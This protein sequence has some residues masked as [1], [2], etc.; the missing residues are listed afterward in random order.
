MENPSG[1]RRYINVQVLDGENNE[2]S[3]AWA[4]GSAY[5]AVTDVPA[6]KYTVVTSAWGFYTVQK[7]V[8]IPGYLYVDADNSPRV[9]FNFRDGSGNLV[10]ADE[11]SIFAGDYTV[12]VPHPF[13][14]NGKQFL[15]MT[16]GTY[17]I[18]ISNNDAK[19]V[20]SQRKMRW[21]LQTAY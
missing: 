8:T 17:D 13:W 7:N 21:Y 16:P 18:V 19:L 1:L 5:T 2:I 15:R 9:E 10:E 20:S 14:D 6:G 3:S 4:D 11:T 12:A